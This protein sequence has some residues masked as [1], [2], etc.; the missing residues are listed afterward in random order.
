MAGWCVFRAGRATTL[1]VA[2]LA[3]NAA[4][5]T[6]LKVE[7]GPAARAVKAIIVNPSGSACGAELSFGDGREEKLRLDGR[8]SRQVD[9]TYAAD[10]SFAVRL[11]GDLYVR[12]PARA[13]DGIDSAR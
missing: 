1:L 11:K 8:E 4:A 9:H 7:A 5:Q 12:G 13:V 10:G 3:T 6:A 2:V